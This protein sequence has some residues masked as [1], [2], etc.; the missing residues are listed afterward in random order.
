MKLDFSLRRARLRTGTWTVLAILVVG[1]S[2]LCSVPAV[3]AASRHHRRHHKHSRHRH[4]T[5][6]APT[7]VLLTGL[8]ATQQVWGSH[9]QADPA[10]PNNFDPMP[11]GTYPGALDNDQFYYVVF[12]ELGRISAVSEKLTPGTTQTAANAAIAASLLPPD[13][14]KI[15]GPVQPA[16]GAPCVAEEYESRTLGTQDGGRTGITVTYKSY[17]DLYETA[18][19]SQ[20]VREAFVS[21]VHGVIPPGEFGQGGF[22]ALICG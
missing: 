20:D 6:P 16:G 12:D 22:G 19:T 3:A 5:N 8:G 2:T 7:P 9:H 17:Y 13:A 21:S 15:A 10:H 11:E 4:H 14:K 1:L 18:Y